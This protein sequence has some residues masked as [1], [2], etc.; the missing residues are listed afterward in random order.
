ML[1]KRLVTVLTFFNGVLFRSKNFIPDY[2][3]T[4]NFIDA[5][6]I[7]ELILL[8]ITRPENRN[9]DVFL[10]LVSEFSRRCFVPLCVGGGISSLDDFK[11]YLDAGADKI[12]INTLA[13]KDPILI[14]K[15]AER[16]GSQCIV[17]SIDVRK[18]DDGY[19][20][21]SNCGRDST[22]WSPK[23]FARHVE[24]LGAGELLLTSI[25]KD[26]SLEGYDIELNRSVID[27]VSI[28]VIIS[29]GAGK[30]QDFVDG[31][32]V[33]GAS[34]VATTNIYHFTETSIRSAK[35]FM[36][37]NEINIRY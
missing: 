37:Q 33:A 7:D 13:V 3:Y 6:S 12:A 29:G 14:S 24:N 30:W 1:R 11:V 23:D 16:F 10:N 8:D 35:Q 4:A 18:G 36:I 17:V 25:D 28:P 22:D 21:Y 31:F 32:K 26:G 27:S 19:H 9:R 15:A 20:V 2:R 34:A 5:W